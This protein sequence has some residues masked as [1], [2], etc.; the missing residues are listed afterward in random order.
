MVERDD[1]G[2]AA[3]ITRPEAQA[4]IAEVK[5]ARPVAPGL[6][7]AASGGPRGA[8]GYPGARVAPRHAP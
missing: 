7:P 6:S 4:M 3:P 8:R 1:S 5:G 2:V